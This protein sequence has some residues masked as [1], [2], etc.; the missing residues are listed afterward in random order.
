MEAF[1]NNFKFMIRFK[2][3]SIPKP[4]SVDYDSLPY[5]EVKRFCGSCE[6]HVYDFRGKDEAYL[7]DVFTN[8][9]NACGIFYLDEVSALKIN[10]D[11]K[12]I[13]SFLLKFISIVFFIKSFLSVQDSKAA[14]SPTPET[15]QQITDPDSSGIQI[16]YKS[17]VSRSRAKMD[18]YVNDSLYKKSAYEKNGLIFLPDSIK[19]DDIIKVKILK[20][21]SFKAK[22]YKFTYSNTSNIIITIKGKDPIRLFKRR[23]ISGCPSNFW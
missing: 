8:S 17:R 11:K 14:Q 1:G 18:I 7:N 6:K 9:P 5:N 20:S 3:I 23:H 13:N 4:C 15:V 12:Y 16:Q 19:P 2:N 10:P 21:E 22:T